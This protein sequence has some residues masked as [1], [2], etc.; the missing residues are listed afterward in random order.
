MDLLAQ[1]PLSQTFEPHD[2]A[3]IALLVVLEG[4]MSIDNAMVLGLLA[5]RLPVGEQGKALAY[6]LGGAFLFRAVAI[7]FAAFLLTITWMKLL[8]GAY[9][10]YLAIHHFVAGERDDDNETALAAGAGMDGAPVHDVWRFWRTV[11]AIELTDIAFAIDSIIAA[12]GVVGPHPGGST[13]A[14]FH[15]KL[16]VVI[17]GGILGVVLMRFAA[18]GFMKLLSRFPRL[19]TSA[20][21]LVAVIGLKLVLDWQFNPPHGT[22]DHVLDFHSPTHWAFWAF[23]VAMAASFL[24]G[25][26]P[27]RAQQTPA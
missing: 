27:R 14:T 22:M 19:E 20:Y 6:G 13:A 21:L 7:V 12:I 2:M 17:T 10:L 25:F 23:W 8:G 11:L 26:V 24:V 9:L 4:V 3:V 1:L 18:A 15:P 16:W 5:R